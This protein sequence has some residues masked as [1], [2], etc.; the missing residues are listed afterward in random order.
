M[1]LRW[2]ARVPIALLALLV[3]ALGYFAWRFHFVL[4]QNVPTARSGPLS[5]QLPAGDKL[6]FFVIGDSGS[7]DS[8]QLKVAEAM[9][10]RCREAGLDGIIHVGDIFYEVGVDSVDDPQWQSK[11]EIP[12]GLPCLRG[13]PIYPV[14]GNHDLTTNPD[15][16]IEYGRTH[17]RWVQPYRF[18]E[19]RFGNLLQLVALDGWYPDWCGDPER[20]TLDFARQATAQRSTTW[21]VVFSHYPLGSGNAKRS[22]SWRSRILRWA[23]CDADVDLYFAGHDHH[24]EHRVDPACRPELF[25]SGTGGGDL[26]PVKSF[27]PQSRFLLSTHG[28]AELELDSRSATVRFFD[29][30]SSLRYETR[31]EAAR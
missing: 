12:Y 24:L 18:Y 22:L 19:R 20:C 11:V 31:L 2:L 25:V 28:F 17:P 5:A 13:K 14:H 15:A 3:L 6:R 30:D 23:L 10:R 26:Y 8:F 29:A 4:I 27:D 16:Q 7:G 1:T 9:D 21:R